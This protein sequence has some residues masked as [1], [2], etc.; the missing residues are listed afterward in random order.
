L[1]QTKAIEVI[2]TMSKKKITDLTKQ[3][4]YLLGWRESDGSCFT[5]PRGPLIK[6]WHHPKCKCAEG[7]DCQ[8]YGGSE[9]TGCTATD[10]DCP[11]HHL[12]ECLALPN[13]LAPE[14]TD[15]LV[16]EILKQTDF[17]HFVADIHKAAATYDLCRADDWNELVAQAFVLMRMEEGK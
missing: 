2:K 10:V 8:C 3:I 11:H 5:V 9:P 14:I 16:K 13:C 4:F 12:N 7:G 1:G 17:E 6:G 15:L